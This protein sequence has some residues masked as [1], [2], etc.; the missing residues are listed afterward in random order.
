MDPTCLRAVELAAQAWNPTAFGPPIF[1]V[2]MHDGSDTAF[3][4]HQG[5][6]VLAI[7]ADPALAAAGA[8]RFADAVSRGQL[9][10][11]NV[12]IAER[13]GTA[14]FWICEDNSVWNSF[15]VN[16]ASRNRSAHHRIR[17]PTCRFA[18]V[19][20]RFGVPEYLKIDIEG[21][22]ALCV[23]D[24]RPATLP[25]FI[26]V[27][28]E[29]TGDGQTLDAASAIRMLDLLRDVGYTKFKLVSQ[30]DFTTA[31][32]PDRWRG[33]RRLC[34]SA[35]YGKLRRFGLA[36]L[37]KR[38]TARERLR[39]RNDGYEFHCGSSGPWGAGLDGRWST[40]GEARASYLGL[41]DRFFSRRDVK[42]YAFWYDW[43]ATK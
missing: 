32:Y 34:D 30:D 4:L 18:E 41:R 6:A 20:D 3:Y 8:R 2:G 1:D 24:L 17:I 38:F 11:L 5:H 7:E 14:P 21:A 26:S 33:V 31:V 13:T 42:T 27:E 43:H 28:S 40:Y 10:I 37:V 15:D 29:C 36:P 35:A 12:G 25:T 19:I 39:K 22:D 23:K 9:H 16:V